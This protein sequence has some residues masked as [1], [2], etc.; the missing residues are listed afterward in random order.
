MGMVTRRAKR[1]LLPSAVRNSSTATQKFEEY[2]NHAVRLFL[3]VTNASGTGG[4]TVQIRAYDKY[5]NGPVNL[6]VGGTPV[7]TT[8]IY[9]YEMAPTQSTASGSILEFVNR[10]LPAWWDAIVNHADGSN[11]TYSLACEVATL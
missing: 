4:L 8:G 3:N 1:G 9:I 5:G 6:T 2:E 10:I 7:T 11:Y